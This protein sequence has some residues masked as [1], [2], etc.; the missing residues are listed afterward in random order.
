MPDAQHS[1]LH[2]SLHA[3]FERQQQLLRRLFK[4]LFSV[5]GTMWLCVYALPDDQLNVVQT[6]R[7]QQYQLYLLLL[8]LW[9]YSYRRESMAMTTLIRVAENKAVPVSAVDRSTL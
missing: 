3:S 9:G 4:V 1:I 6:F 5:A 7:Q 8:T 2:H